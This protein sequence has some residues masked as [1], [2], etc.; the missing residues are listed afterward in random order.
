M[1]R[2]L[3]TIVVLSICLFFIGIAPV[4]PTSSAETTTVCSILPPWPAGF[5][6]TNVSFTPACGNPAFPTIPN[7]SHLESYYDKPGGSV[8]EVCNDNIFPLNW[9]LTETF[10]RSTQC[11]GSTAGKNMARLRA[12]S[13]SDTSLT[14]C[15]QSPI[16]P[17][18][19]FV[20]Q[21]QDISG[22][23]DLF[24]TSH[25]KWV[26]ERD[27]PRRV[28]VVYLVPADK[29]VRKDYQIAIG[30]AIL[31]L[32]N[33]YQSQMDASRLVR[34]VSFST[35]SPLVE[36][37]RTSHTSSFYRSSTTNSLD[38]WN[39]VLAD[40][41]ALSG[42]SFN[43]PNNRW[44]YYIDADPG[45]VG[46]N[47]QF[48]GGT[49]GVAL[50]PAN[51]LRGLTRQ[52]TIG[53]CGQVSDGSGPCRWIGGLGHELGHAFGLPHPPGCDQ[54]N[55]SGGTAARDSLMYLGY[56]FYPNTTLLPANVTQLFG[57]GFFTNLALDGPRFD[58]NA[59]PIDDQRVFARVQYID[60]L[61]RE[62][63]PAG[64]NGW[65]SYIYQCNSSDW[66]CINQ[67]RI[68]TARGFLESIEFKDIVL[69][70][71]D[72]NCILR[73]NAPTSDAYMQEYVRQ[74]YRVYLQR[75]PE[76]NAWFDYIKSTGGSNDG[77]NNLVGGFINS[78]EYRLRFG[79]P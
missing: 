12:V 25:L 44:I 16:P 49:S 47:P 3:L 72:G 79:P 27:P 32:Q 18:W 57:T 75:E 38:F 37:Y 22:C 66:T 74:L 28:H 29:P 30:N 34:G 35:N 5:L 48:V 7:T 63:D 69:C 61:R 33:F 6:R 2:K 42:G 9:V 45:C 24:A 36:V 76:S 58:C 39:K 1:N 56:L 19:H 21:F 43:D 50:L 15:A 60:I 71:R 17:G 46:G 14:I 41:F 65:S 64:L 23:G 53:L 68:N 10:W 55:C 31:H 13:A 62:P 73:N 8:M 51:D 67:R 52:Q 11:N 20:R 70:Q 59:N 54:G 40:G 26:I 77:Y 78:I 4:I